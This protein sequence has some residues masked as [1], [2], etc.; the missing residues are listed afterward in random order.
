MAAVAVAAF[1]VTPPTG[2]AN[3]APGRTNRAAV[4][5]DTGTEVRRRCVRFSAESISGREALDLADVQPVYR[6]YSGE[7]VAVCALC[8]V[9]CPADNSCL[10]CGGA[11]HW[12]YHRADAGKTEFTSS[13]GGAG[14]T[15]VTDGDVEGWKW[16]TGSAP[17]WSSVDDVC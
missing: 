8:Q 1:A 10:T 3:Q 7:G 16:G 12:S 17:V 14:R 6:S 15:R 4:I 11:N 2:V 9:G 5:V 13:G